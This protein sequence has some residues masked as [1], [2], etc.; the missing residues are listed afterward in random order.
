MS[1]PPS[2]DSRKSTLEERATLAG[3]L[4]T[5]NAARLR[6]IARASRALE[7]EDAVQQALLAF[8]RSYPDE[9][10]NEEG[11]L[12]YLAS[13]IQSAAWKQLRTLARKPTVSPNPSNRL[14]GIEMDV[15]TDARAVDPAEHVVHSERMREKRDALGKLP[16][17]QQ[18]VLLLGAAGY[19]VTEIAEKLGMTT[20][21]VRK[22]VQKGNA[23]LRRNLQD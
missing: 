23:A 9:A 19:G 17:D 1:S 4:A 14:P 12:N 11:A 10:A 8:I 5:E 15:I 21:Q 18:Q 6:A 3:K 16:A 13:C 2:P 7:P 22:R 20:R